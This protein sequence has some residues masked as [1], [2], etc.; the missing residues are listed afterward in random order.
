MSDNEIARLEDAHPRMLSAEELPPSDTNAYLVYLARLDSDESRRTMRDCLDRIAG[1]ATGTEDPPPL[2]WS[3]QA[4]A[5]HLLRHQ[6]T[7]ALRARMHERVTNR[8]GR[9]SAPWS[10]SHI[11]KHLVA[12]RSVLKQAWKL[13]DMTTDDYMRAVAIDSAKGH[14]EPVGRSIRA[15]EFAA[16]LAACREDPQPAG[17]R[18]AAIIAV[19]HS[20][21]LRRSEIAKARRAD[22]DAGVGSLRVIGKGNKQ[23]TV[24]IHADAA[25][26]VTAWLHVSAQVRG[27]LFC[28]VTRHGTLVDRPMTPRAVAALVDKRRLQ[29]GLTRLA[30]HDF[31]RTFAGDLLDAGADLVQVKGLLGHTS[32]DVTARYDRRPERQRQAAVNRLTLPAPQKLHDE[33]T[34]SLRDEE[35]LPHDDRSST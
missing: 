26:Y 18:D 13:G 31:R 35:P 8:A 25:P 12:L 2:P 23:R 4:F 34:E 1:M 15:E 24:Y 32:A 6:H 27:P 20:T 28:P 5:W 10:P 21:G 19:L 22:Y 33:P 7:A 30:P 14:R 9:V 17:A 11:N 3:G 29:A 16:M